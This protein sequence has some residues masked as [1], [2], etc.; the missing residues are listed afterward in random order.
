MPLH[1]PMPASYNPCILRPAAT[2]T[3]HPAIIADQSAAIPELSA[4]I[5]K[6]SAR[7][8]QHSAVAGRHSATIADCSAIIQN[9][10]TGR[11]GVPRSHFIML[12]NGRGAL[13]SRPGV[14]R[15]H[16]DPVVFLSKTPK[17]GLFRYQHPG[18]LASRRRVW[19][20][21]PRTGE[22]PVFPGCFRMFIPET[23]LG[24]PPVA[25][26]AGLP[27]AFSTCFHDKIAAS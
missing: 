2:L 24:N 19:Q 15:N 3:P 23:A 14:L 13:R 22:T 10:K 11:C 12:R 5:K 27:I 17:T 4:V 1:A 21:P 7:I 6:C 25:Q 9:S 18:A 26:L 16:C 8:G 20:K